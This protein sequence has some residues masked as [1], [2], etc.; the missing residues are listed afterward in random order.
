M[1]EQKGRCFTRI[2]FV[3]SGT[4][5]I[6][7]PRRFQVI[8]GFCIECGEITAQPICFECFSRFDLLEADSELENYKA[9]L[10]KGLPPASESSSLDL[11]SEVEEEE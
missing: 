5:R 2:L 1:R 7:N 3:Q 11:Y 9:Y 4:L 10:L 6:K 8:M